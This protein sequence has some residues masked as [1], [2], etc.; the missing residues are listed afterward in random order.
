[1]KRDVQSVELPLQWQTLPLSI[2]ILGKKWKFRLVDDALESGNAG[3]CD[4]R[5]KTIN[6]CKDEEL[7]DDAV[8]T[9]LHELLHSLCYYGNLG[10][11]ENEE[12]VVAVLATTLLEVLVSN[13]DLTNW[14]VDRI[15]E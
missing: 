7:A 10:L 15:Q 8:D 11:G 4:Y 3:N 9:V 2:K 14:L 12:R 6:L 13:P 5:S 1:M